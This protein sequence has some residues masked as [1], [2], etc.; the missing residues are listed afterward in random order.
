[1]PIYFDATFSWSGYSY[2][3]KVGMFIVLK[4]LNEYDGDDIETNFNDWALEFEWLEY[5]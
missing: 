3:G 1:M 5:F 2:Q 4:K